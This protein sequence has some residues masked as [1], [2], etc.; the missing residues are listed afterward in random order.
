MNQET[1]APEHVE[2]EEPVQ[3]ADVTISFGTLAV[4]TVEEEPEYIS[5]P[6]VAPEP[7]ISSAPAS[8]EKPVA[9]SASKLPEA[10]GRR[11]SV[12]ARVS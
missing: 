11:G 10:R 2:I 1:F 5:P 6:A 7:H 12:I 8:P 3:Y 4:N 9:A